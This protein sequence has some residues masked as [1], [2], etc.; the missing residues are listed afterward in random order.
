MKILKTT[1]LEYAKMDIDMDRKTADLLIKYANDN[2]DKKAKE[3][4][5]IEWAFVDII[6]K[7]LKY[8]VD[9]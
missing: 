1:K 5:L 3:D 6:K 7:R 2:M 9:K 4:Y 8:G